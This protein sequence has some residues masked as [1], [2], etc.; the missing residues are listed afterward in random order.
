M[1][2]LQKQESILWKRRSKAFPSAEWAAALFLAKYNSH[3]LSYFLP[4]ACS[5]AGVQEGRT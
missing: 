4:Y 1:V 3:A 2:I 5:Q